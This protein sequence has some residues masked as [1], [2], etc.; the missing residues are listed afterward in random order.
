MSESLFVGSGYVALYIR[1]ARTLKDRRSVIQGIIQKLKNEGFSVVEIDFG[2]DPKRVAV[3]FT[4]VGKSNA[5]VEE[6]FDWA[7]TLFQGPYYIV[8]K[9]KE[10]FQWE[11][12]EEE[13]FQN[14]EDEIYE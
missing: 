6:K 1:G 10:V 11:V 7:L 8:S 12:N 14:A 5:F 4:L 2:E 3:A 13:G 9:K